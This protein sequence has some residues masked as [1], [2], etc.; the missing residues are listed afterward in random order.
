MGTARV[1]SSAGEHVA[2]SSTRQ[3]WTRLPPSR[4]TTDVWQRAD[5]SV[6]E[7]VMLRFRGT[8]SVNFEVISFARTY[9]SRAPPASYEYYLP[10]NV[11]ATDHQR[12]ERD[13]AGG[14]ALFQQS[15]GILRESGRQ[16]WYVSWGTPRS[17]AGQRLNVRRVRQHHCSVLDGSEKRWSAQKNSCELYIMRNIC[18]RM[19]QPVGLL[20]HQRRDRNTSNSTPTKRARAY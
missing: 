3:L 9:A 8:G 13:R 6:L 12:P 16:L 11:P 19:R 18:P 5:A 17:R 7:L 20:P 14:D 10:N 1:G 15:G 2:T 4:V